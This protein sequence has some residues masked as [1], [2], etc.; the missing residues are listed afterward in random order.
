MTS[1]DAQVESPT[2]TGK[3]LTLLTSTLTW[4]AAHQRRLNDQAESD[5]RLQLSKDDTDG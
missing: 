4:L 3:S 2:G 5:L 1:D